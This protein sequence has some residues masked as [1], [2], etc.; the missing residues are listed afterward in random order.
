MHVCVSGLS[1]TGDLSHTPLAM[2]RIDLASWNFLVG[3]SVRNGKGEPFCMSKW[4]DEFHLILQFGISIY[5]N[6][7]D[8]ADGA[9]KG[10]FLFQ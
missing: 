8:S 5:I 1:D 10:V 6:N 4:L 3:Y 7:R 9:T 2:H